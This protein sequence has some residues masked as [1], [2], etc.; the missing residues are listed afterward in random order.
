MHCRGRG[1]L[2][3]AFIFSLFVKN[4]KNTLWMK[5]RLRFSIPSPFISDVKC[6][7]N[8]DFSHFTAFSGLN[9]SELMRLIDLPNFLCSASAMLAVRKY[10]F[11]LFI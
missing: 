6:R 3:P 10:K 11:L 5:F 9:I 1:Q 2:S 4:L 8:T 7:T